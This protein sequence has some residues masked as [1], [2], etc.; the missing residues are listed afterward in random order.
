MQGWVMAALPLAVGAALFAIE[1]L[2]GS[3]D[4][5]LATVEA[6]LDAALTRKL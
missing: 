4:R 5:E 6:T 3:S 1:A 2:D